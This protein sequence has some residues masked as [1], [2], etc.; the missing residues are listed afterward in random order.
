MKV[1]NSSRYKLIFSVYHHPQ[2]GVMVEPYV[3][4]VTQANTL[5]LTYQKLFSGNAGHYTKLTAQQQD[6]IALLDPIMV[7]N[8]IRLFSPVKRIRPKEYFNKHFKRDQYKKEIR[9]FI[10][11]HILALMRALPKD[12]KG[13]YI[14]DEINPASQRINFEEGF[15]R[16]LF[17]LRRNEHGTRYFATIKHNDQRIPIHGRWVPCCSPANLLFS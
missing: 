13:M 9:P 14:A 10:E 5:S 7:E 1:E 12:F 16:V 6:W 3:V 4:A 2:L 11:K 8:I 15:A 17:H